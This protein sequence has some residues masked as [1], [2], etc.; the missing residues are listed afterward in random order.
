MTGSI[1]TFEVT[2]SCK[3]PLRLLAKHNCFP[4]TEEDAVLITSYNG[5][6]DR[7]V[8]LKSLKSPAFREWKA[9]GWTLSIIGGSR[10][11]EQE[12]ETY[13]TWPC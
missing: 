8:R 7:T 4:A 1:T 6:K 13:H 9:E 12:Y 3:F 5:N 10:V 2:G 11:I